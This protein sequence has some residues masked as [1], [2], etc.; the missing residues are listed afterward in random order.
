M[1]TVFKV[2]SNVRKR[3]RIHGI[4]ELFNNLRMHGGI[5]EKNPVLIVC[6]FNSEFDLN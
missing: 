3:Y 2:Q 5:T 4:Y 1:F 6:D